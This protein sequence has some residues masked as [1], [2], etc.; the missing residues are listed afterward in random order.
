MLDE[1]LFQFP[2]SWAVCEIGEAGAAIVGQQKTAQSD[3]GSGHYPYLRVANVLDDE[4]DLRGL[5]HMHFTPDARQRYAL[6]AGDVLLCESQSREL[7]GRSALYHGELEEL[8]FQNHILRFRP[9]EE[10]FP[11]YAL[12]VF[13]AYQKSGVFAN[14]AKGATNL[15]HIGL[16]RFQKLPFPVPP[17][18]TQI[19]IATTARAAQN[20]VDLIRKSLGTAMDWARLLPRHIR[21]YLILT[22]SEMHQPGEVSSTVGRAEWRTAAEVVAPDAPIVYGILQ[23]G[24]EV[25]DGT[26]VPYIRGQD[27]RDGEILEHQLRHTSEAVNQ[28]YHRSILSSGDVLLGLVRHTRVAVVPPQ[29][30][31]AN[32][33]QGTAVFHPGPIVDSGY[34]AHWL[35]SESAQQWLHRHMRGIDMPGL[36]LRDVRRL[37]VPVIELSHQVEITQALDAAIDYTQKIQEGLTNCD[38]ALT[39]LEGELL[40]RYAYG[41]EAEAIGSETL[42][43]RQSSASRDLVLLLRS[44]IITEGNKVRAGMDRPSGQLRRVEV[45]TPRSATSEHLLETL[46]SLGGRLTPEDLYHGMELSESDVDAFFSALRDLL[47]GGH[48]SI[49]RPDNIRV[50]I[51]AAD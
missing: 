1:K 3:R 4:L 2:D 15:S 20:E 28:K 27:L 8:Y 24:P 14:I 34:L 47:E 37:P 39:E 11:E 41:R 35:A 6:Q 25:T 5:A 42:G 45:I 10:I 22:D 38:R 30:E 16:K 12:L 46:R 32:V 50:F 19:A 43:A 29:L 18:P 9:A 48:V 36:N 40:R 26:G 23:P 49:D 13:R 7:V 33:T 21:D 44:R 51:E 31:G 17:R